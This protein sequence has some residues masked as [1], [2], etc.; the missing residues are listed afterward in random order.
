MASKITFNTAVS[1]IKRAIKNRAMKN[2]IVSAVDLSGNLSSVTGPSR[3]AIIRRAFNDLIA[4]KVL[5]PTN[6]T[7]YNKDTHHPVRVYRYTGK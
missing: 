4:E 2:G 1:T 7:E 5:R 3:G 6:R